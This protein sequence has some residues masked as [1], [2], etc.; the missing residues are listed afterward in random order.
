MPSRSPPIFPLE[1]R[2]LVRMGERIRA[3]RLRCQLTTTTAARQAG[4]SRTTLYRVEA[5][6]SAVTMGS[7]LRVLAT[8][9]RERDIDE[10]AANTTTHAGGHRIGPPGVS[11]PAQRPSRAVMAR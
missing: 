2:R 11:A 6:D 4:I 7:Y 10:L 5:G 9:G 8:L 1:Q 3:A